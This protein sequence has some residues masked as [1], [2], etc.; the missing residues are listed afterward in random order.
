M[1]EPKYLYDYGERL[2]GVHWH[3][4][5]VLDNRAIRDNTRPKAKYVRIEGEEWAAL[6]ER[7]RHSL[8]PVVGDYWAAT[9][10]LRDILTYLGEQP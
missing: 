1:S 5:F 6:M 9:A 7:A 3:A 8:D 10:S 2:I 4:T